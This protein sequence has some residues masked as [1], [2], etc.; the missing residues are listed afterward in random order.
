MAIELARQLR[1]N[2]GDRGGRSGRGRDQAAAAGAR[3]ISLAGMLPAA[4]VYGALL[5]PFFEKSN[6]TS[7]I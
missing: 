1:E 2:L 4:T 6:S 3:S 7:P 5:R